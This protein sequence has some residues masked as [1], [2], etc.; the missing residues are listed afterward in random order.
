[1][2]P[3]PVF[4]YDLG[5][6]ACYLVAERISAA[7]P[8]VPEWEP[9][10]G[11][12]FEAQVP[13]RELIARLVGEYGL[14]PLSWPREWPPDTRF[15]MLAATYAKRVGRA[16]AFSLACFRQVFAAGRDL[17]DHDTVLIAGAACEMHPA[18]LLKGVELRSVRE[19]L[20]QASERAKRAGARTLPAIEVGGQTFEGQAGIELAGVA[21]EQAR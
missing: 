5:S 14:Q 1:V 2:T 11:E 6:P 17:G 9:V 10:L 4:Y 20:E 16:V 7:L 21:L 3:A 19:A 15:A 18:A 8:V 12:Q 13:D